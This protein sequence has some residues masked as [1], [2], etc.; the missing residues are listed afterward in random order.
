MAMQAEEIVNR[1]N[2]LHPNAQIDVAGEDCSFAVYVV[3]DEFAGKLTMQRQQPILALFAAELCSGKLH[4]LS[5]TAKTPTEL[6][7]QGGLVQ[8]QFA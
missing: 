8:I 4:A 6:Q 7:S 1:I 3:S 5:V 2:T